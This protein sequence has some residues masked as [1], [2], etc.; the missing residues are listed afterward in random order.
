MK[1]AYCGD[2]GSVHYAQKVEIDEKSELHI[3][4]VHL[5]QALG[6]NPRSSFEAAGR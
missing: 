5:F 2:H 1:L 3:S 4:H 6:C